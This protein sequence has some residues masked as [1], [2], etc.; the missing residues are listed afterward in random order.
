[1]AKVAKKA[2]KAT[3]K[4]AKKTK[5]ASKKKGDTLTIICEG[6]DYMDY[7]E[8]LPLANDD[9]PR[10]LDAEGKKQIRASL[11][12]LGLFKPFIVR[13][14]APKGQPG[15]IAGNQR[16]LVIGDLYEEG[17]E[18]PPLP[19]DPIDCDDDTAKAIILRDNV[20]DGE[21]EMDG[22]S[23]YVAE[24][25]EKHGVDTRDI[26]G[27]SKKEYGDVLEHYKKMEEQIAGSGAEAQKSVEERKQELIKYFKS[28][29]YSDTEAE[30]RAELYMYSGVGQEWVSTEHPTT[31]GAKSA[32]RIEVPFWFDDPERANTVIQ[33][34]SQKG[35]SELDAVRLYS[36]AARILERKGSNSEAE[37]RP[38]KKAKKAKKVKK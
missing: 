26:L 6:A 20:N 21:W 1:M 32:Q 31:K 15:L 16:L 33:A 27:L 18:I 9:N 29:N 3:A 34:F 22:Y 10:S 25:S 2:K 23:R 11:E 24:L 30:R 38:V 4:K 28:Q 8:L 37:E 35:T 19:V 17:W 13:R 14:N 7:E 5:K 12:E 36:L